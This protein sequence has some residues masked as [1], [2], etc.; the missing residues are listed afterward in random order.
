MPQEPPDDVLLENCRLCGG[1]DFTD[2]KEHQLGGCIQQVLQQKKR[3]SRKK[4]SENI[5]KIAN[6]PKKCPVC[7]FWLHNLAESVR[8]THI[9][10]CIRED[11]SREKGQSKSN[12]KRKRKKPADSKPEDNNKM[13]ASKLK[14]TQITEFFKVPQ[15]HKKQRAS[16]D[17]SHWERVLVGD[18]R[19]RKKRARKLGV[20]DLTYV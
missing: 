8:Q 4:S 5:S 2:I 17:K 7:R 13:P 14:T 15:N 11:L 16:T 3:K 9:D 19:R 12:R 20:I 10:K 1:C 6:L 18:G